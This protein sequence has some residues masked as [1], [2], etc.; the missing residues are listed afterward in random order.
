MIYGLEQIKKACNLFSITLETG[1]N[2]RIR[3]LKLK[4]EIV[5]DKLKLA[6]DDRDII[7]LAGKLIDLKRKIR[8]L[9]TPTSKDTITDEMISIA[10]SHPIE[11]LVEFNKGKALAWCHDDKY[12][13]M[14]LDL[15]RNKCRCF[16][17][18]KS[19]DSISILMERDGMTFIEAVRSMQ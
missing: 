9:N 1:I 17:C 6:E 14:S 3:Y 4:A 11:L 19:F 13:S 7:E 16:V 2:L 8:W 18:D 10:R 12:P 15:K 5:R